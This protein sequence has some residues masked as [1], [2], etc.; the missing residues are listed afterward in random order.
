PLLVC[1]DGSMASDA[2]MPVARDWAGALRTNIVLA[3]VFHPLDVEAAVDPE[4]VVG[5]AAARLAADIEVELRVVRGY[6]PAGT[7]VA[8]VDGLEPTLVA[9]ATHGRTG[10]ARA[11]LGRVAM[12]VVRRSGCPALVVRPDVAA[13]VSQ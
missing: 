7:I 13:S 12:A 3:H 6:S 9:L 2:I 5:E 10:T 4:A 8:L 11:A 1:H